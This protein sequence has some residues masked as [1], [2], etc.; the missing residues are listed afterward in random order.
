MDKLQK[1]KKSYLGIWILGALVLGIIAG[2]CLQ[3][4]AEFTTNYLKPIGTIYVN[5]L[6]LLVVPVVLFSIIDGV[7]SLGSV[8]KVGSIGWKTVVFFLVT[9]ALAIVIGLCA[10]YAFR[11]TFPVLQAPDGSE[12]TV[13][14][15]PNFMDTF[16]KIFPSNWLTPLVNSDMLPT[17]V[18]AILVGVGILLTGDDG[19]RV[20]DNLHSFYVVVM[21]IMSIV[22]WLTPL[23]VFCLM[24]NVVALNGASILGA[25]G[26]VLLA[27]YIAYIVHM[28]LVYGLTLKLIARLSPIAFIKKMFPAMTTAFTTTSSNATLPLTIDGTN[29][30]GCDNEV[31]SFVLPLGCTINMDGAAIYM[32]VA[33]VFIAKC[34]G[35]DL[36][37]TQ[38]I[39]IVLTSTL[40]SI[41]SAGVPGAAKVM[42]VMVLESIGVPVE[43]A[44][45]LWGID[46]LFDMG[47]TCLN[48]TGDSVCALAVDRIEK[49]KR[50]KTTK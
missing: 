2:I 17:I 40:A 13:P 16:V 8:K 18:I 15:V 44:I 1:Q 50:M 47:R 21:K 48:V 25:L 43:G 36:T 45:I 29:S 49:A 28:V 9:T 39:T 26:F 42:L 14:E 41:G 4:Q 33:S 34:Y 31:S 10:A 7:F 6:K 24:T 32:G 30:L 22:L 37:L 27:T 11:G 3:S 38:L 12:I 20:G 19:K 5:L 23:G 46:V 35:I